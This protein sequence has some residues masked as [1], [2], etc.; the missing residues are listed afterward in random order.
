MLPITANLVVLF[1]TLNEKLPRPCEFEFWVRVKSAP[2]ELLDELELL[3]LDDDEEED[4][5]L[6]SSPPP[7]EQPNASVP[8][9]ARLRYLPQF[10]SFRM[11]RNP[12]IGFGDLSDEVFFLAIK[13]INSLRRLRSRENGH[14][15]RG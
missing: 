8:T 3:E 7:A 6:S 9:S 15:G 1:G 14:G 2:P 5:E 13:A 4:D 11:Q 12:V 10:F